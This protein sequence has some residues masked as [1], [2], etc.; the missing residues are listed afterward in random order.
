MADTEDVKA[1]MQNFRSGQVFQ[2]CTLPS[3]VSPLH[4]LHCVACIFVANNMYKLHGLPQVIV[5]GCD[6]VFTSTLWKLLFKLAGIGSSSEL[7]L[8]PQS[9]GYSQRVNECLETFLRCF[10][11]ACLSSWSQWLTLAKYWYNTSSYSA[12]G[13]SPFEVLYGFP[14]C[15]LGLDLALASPAP[16]QT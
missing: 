14:P 5:S 6:K 10:V 9:D 16:V 12:L 15:H 2:V 4:R 1:G 7:R 13:R 3:L 8:P 11:H